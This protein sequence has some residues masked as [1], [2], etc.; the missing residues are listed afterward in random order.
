MH[1]WLHATRATFSCDVRACMMIE[2]V[3]LLHLCASF[4]MDGQTRDTVAL[5]VLAVQM[6]FLKNKIDVL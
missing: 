3:L 6:E 4:V 2:F 1:C 5:S